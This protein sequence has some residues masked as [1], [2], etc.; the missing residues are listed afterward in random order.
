MKTVAEI[1]GIE[2]TNEELY[3]KALTHS[4]YTKEK[5][6]WDKWLGKVTKINCREK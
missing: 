5:T 4:S 6:T 1:F 3:K 2:T